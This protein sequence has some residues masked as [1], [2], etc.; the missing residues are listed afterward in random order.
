MRAHWDVDPA[1]SIVLQA[2]RFG[3]AMLD[4]AY[5]AEAPF[6]PDNKNMSAVMI[7][8]A[9]ITEIEYGQK[10]GRRVGVR[11]LDGYFFGAALTQSAF[12][13]LA[14]V[15]ASVLALVAAFI[16]SERSLPFLPLASLT[17]AA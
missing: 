10:A 8:Y 7:P 3:L 11:F 5:P 9:A 4:R 12:A 13:F 17:A 15:P 14:A 2:A 6:T 1:A 16:A